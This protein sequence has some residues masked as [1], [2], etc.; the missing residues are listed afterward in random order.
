MNDIYFMQEAIYEAKKARELMEVPIGA[1]I[2]RDDKIIGRGYNKN[3]RMW[4]CYE[5]NKQ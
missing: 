5:Y 4:Y 3:W 1:V 2:V